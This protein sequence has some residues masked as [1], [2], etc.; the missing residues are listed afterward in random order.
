MVRY[1]QVKEEKEK[2]LSDAG[3]ENHEL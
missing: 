2:A 1:E 3:R